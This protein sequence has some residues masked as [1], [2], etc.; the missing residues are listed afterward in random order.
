MT[1]TIKIT[2]ITILLCLLLYYLSFWVLPSVTVTNNSNALISHARVDLPNS[3]LDF[4]KLPSNTENSIH[5][6]LA[7]LD[8]QYHYKITLSNGKTFEGSCGYV[9]QNQINKRTVITV[10][11]NQV[12]CLE[13]I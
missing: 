7:Q 11:D 3:G 13:K 6:Q 5:Y 2:T 1:R 12:N 10:E 4:G 9:T 8:G